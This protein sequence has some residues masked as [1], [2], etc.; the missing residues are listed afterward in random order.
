MR[1][2]IAE[3]GD[4]GALEF[5]FCD[6]VVPSQP[7]ESMRT[8]P[9]RFDKEEE[10]EDRRGE[11]GNARSLET[12]AARSAEE[13][14]ALSVKRNNCGILCQEAPAAARGAH[15]RREAPMAGARAPTRLFV[16]ESKIAVYSGRLSRENVFSGH[17]SRRA[18]CSVS[19]SFPRDLEL[20]RM[21]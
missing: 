3:A 14:R 20:R 1:N 7:E 11:S 8:T 6:A 5:F 17:F 19:G 15:R 18:R 21:A 12:P 9:P 16:P 13:D 10:E 4:N 2:W